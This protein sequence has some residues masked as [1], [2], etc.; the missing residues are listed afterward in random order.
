MSSIIVLG[1]MWGDEGKAKIVDFIGAEVDVVTRFQGGAN[2]GH[3]IV[4]E[5]K[6]YVFH[7][8][9]SGILYPETQCVIGA[10]TVID[11]LGL[12]EEMQS[13]MLQGIDFTDR[14][15]ID[16]RAGLVLA[17]HKQL[18]HKS[19]ENLGTG[20]IGTTGKGIGPAYSDQAARCALRMGDLR[21]PEWL[22]QRLNNFYKYH[23]INLSASDYKEELES[24]LEVGKF[25]GPFMAQT[26]QML[27]DWYKEGKK[28]LFEGAQGTLLDLIYGT[29]PFV[30]SSHTVSGGVCVGTGFPPRWL[31]RILGVF[32]AYTTRVGA[33]PFPTEIEG[34][35]ADQIRH[36]GNEYGSTT[37]RP[38]RIGWF[39]AVAAQYSAALNGL[40][41]L[42]ITLLDVLTG[43]PELKI[44]HSYIKH[45][46]VL[47]GFV[48]HPIELNE[49]QPEYL[50]LPGWDIDISNIKTWKALPKET[51][52]YLEAIQD[53]L[54]LPVKI[55]SVGQDRHQTIVIKEKV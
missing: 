24:L 4:L 50:T 14:L 53:L 42:A 46:Q 38:R 17:L 11:P 52:Q 51:K 36:K 9:P 26:D 6:K 32:K 54:K 43:L 8:V 3:T 35:L 49:V 33:G 31:D 16:E 12:R 18:D 22:E 29:Y 2:A 39:D 47:P 10:G 30:T 5:G 21:Y 48:S 19:E 25:L 23:Q 44:C 1:C 55:V 37:G 20:K 45:N 28:I 15:F 41:S 13:L 7:T 34:P 40:D 27:R